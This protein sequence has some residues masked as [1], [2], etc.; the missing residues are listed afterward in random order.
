MIC[1][2][3]GKSWLIFYVMGL[4][5]KGFRWVLLSDLKKF[6]NLKHLTEKILID[7]LKRT[8]PLRAMDDFVRKR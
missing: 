4:L 1:D 7:I 5:K 2:S 6:K 3:L 8:L